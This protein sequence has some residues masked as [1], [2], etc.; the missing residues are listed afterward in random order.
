[1]NIE[2]KATLMKGLESVLNSTMNEAVMKL[3]EKYG[4]DPEEAMN[5]LGCVVLKAKGSKQASKQAN[6]QTESTPKSKFPLPWCGKI[7]EG[8]CYG[9]KPNHG[10]FSQ[11][12]NKPASNKGNGD[13]YGKLCSTCLKQCEKNSHGK[14]NGG[15]V[16]E[17]NCDFFKSPAG[18]EPVLY[19]V[20][21]KKLEIS[22]EEAIEEAKRLGFEIP[23]SEFEEVSSKKRGRPT[24]DEEKPAKEPK[25]RGRPQKPKRQVSVSNAEDLLKDLEEQGQAVY[26]RM[27]KSKD[28]KPPPPEPTTPPTPEEEASAAEAE[29]D[30]VMGEVEITDD[31]QNENG[32]DEDE[33]SNEEV[34]VVPV[35]IGDTEYYMAEDEA[36]QD[37]CEVMDESGEVVGRFKKTKSGAKLVKKGKK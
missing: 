36:E 19:S 22:K 17:R 11:C 27:T 14:P 4:F 13:L 25:K 2:M 37:G 12:Q 31:E 24:N 30:E 29:D 33:N 16:I 21:M 28:V 34:N 1:M 23:E 15:L 32:S 3:S 26:E 5:T 18:K 9:L 7:N 10:L 6:E 8:W 35:K 20:V